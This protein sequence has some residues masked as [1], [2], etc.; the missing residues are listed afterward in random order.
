MVQNLDSLVRRALLGGF[1]VLSSYAAFAPASQA[2]AQDR[3]ARTAYTTASPVA[4][5]RYATPQ[6]QVPQYRADYV[7]GHRQHTPR[8]NRWHYVKQA[9][10]CLHNRCPL[11]ADMPK[12]GHYHVLYPAYPRTPV[13]KAVRVKGKAAQE[14]AAYRN[15]SQGIAAQGIA[16]LRNNVP[17]VVSLRSSG[18]T[19]VNYSPG[20]FANP[21]PVQFPESL[22]P[23]Q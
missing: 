20:E 4:D 14:K 16:A 12:F 3:V 15:A 5:I 17:G 13:A 8:F 23:E 19:P 18:A 2:V 9:V 7:W 22:H 6:Y 10:I 11:L 1:F 21:N